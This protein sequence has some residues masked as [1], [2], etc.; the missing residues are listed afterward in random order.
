MDRRSVGAVSSYTFPN[1]D[2]DHE[3]EVVFM[4]TPSSSGGGGCSAGSGFFSFLLLIPLL[5]IG[6]RR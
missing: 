6:R 2:R 4:E 5:L 1:L 3:I